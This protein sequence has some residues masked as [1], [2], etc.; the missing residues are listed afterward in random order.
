MHFLM[1]GISRVISVCII[2]VAKMTRLIKWKPIRNTEKT[3][4]SK[5]KDWAVIDSN[6]DLR[7]GMMLIVPV[8][9]G[10]TRQDLDMRWIGMEQIN[11]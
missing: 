3:A 6:P 1:H 7:G 5:F 11:G 4:Q 10:I 9:D 2:S 8:V